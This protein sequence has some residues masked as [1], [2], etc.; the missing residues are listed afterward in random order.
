[1]SGKTKKII[2]IIVLV[3]LVTSAAAAY[4]VFGPQGTQG[5]K[6][7]TVKVIHA[8]GSNNSF[9]IETDAEFLRSAVEQEG[10]VSG[11]ESEFGLYVLT[12]DGETVDESLEQWWCITRGGEMLMTGID[13]T[14]IADG[15]IYEFT[16]TT[17]W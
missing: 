17:G 13:D 8:D 5:D 3:V 4:A 1:M 9:A 11:S 10:I 2:A 7:I 14:P 16:L 12:V 6:S 15:E